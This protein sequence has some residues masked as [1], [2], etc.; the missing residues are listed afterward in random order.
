MACVHK[1]HVSQ[2]KYINGTS[3][4]QALATGYDQKIDPGQCQFGKLSSIT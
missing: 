1:R 4:T 2:V 3:G